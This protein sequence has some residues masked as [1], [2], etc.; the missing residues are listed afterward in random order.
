MDLSDGDEYPCGNNDPTNPTSGK[1][2]CYLF[3][4]EHELVGGQPTPGR[5]ASIVMTDFRY[6]TQIKARL[7]MRNP[8]AGK[9]FTIIVKAYKGQSGPESSLVGHKYVGYWKFYNVFLTELTTGGLVSTMGSASTLYVYP[10]NPTLGVPYTTSNPLWM[11]ETSWMVTGAVP[12][13]TGATAL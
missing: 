12:I 3:H 2:K 11:D 6:T 13:G 8:D 9:W 1:A 5:Y 4:G 10:A 7:L